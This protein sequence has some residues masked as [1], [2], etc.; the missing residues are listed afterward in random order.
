LIF[1]VCVNPV[2]FIKTPILNS[3]P[4]LY[5]FLT[6]V[7]SYIL[8]YIVYGLGILKDDFLKSKSST[9]KIEN[10]VKGRTDFNLAMNKYNS[11]ITQNN[12][13][14]PLPSTISTR[15]LRTLSFGFLN[16]DEKN[17]IYTFMFRSDLCKHLYNTC[18]II[19]FLG[20]INF[21]LEKYVS[22]KIDLFT[23][24][25]KSMS[26]FFFM[27]IVAFIF[28]ATRN[29]FYEKAI[30]LPFSIYLSKR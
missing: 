16:N 21:L 26:L 4:T 29:Y 15:E 7:I 25:N 13:G 28:R 23:T 9:K 18:L 1:S 3:D 17:L 19:G 10:K 6:I 27:L 14:A 22:K 5:I 20:V 11:Y 2:Y 8:G 12:L 24:D 30:K